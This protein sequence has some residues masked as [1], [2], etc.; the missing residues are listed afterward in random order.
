MPTDK[1]VLEQIVY[2][3]TIKQRRVLSSVYLSSSG[4]RVGSQSVILDRSDSER[5][6]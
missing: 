5:Y 6:Y 3:I 2:D 1:T 4:S